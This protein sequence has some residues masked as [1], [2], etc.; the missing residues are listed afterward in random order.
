MAVVESKL[1]T[2]SLMLGTAPGTEFACQATNVRI[3][4]TFNEEGDEVETLCGDVLAPS[5]TA[6]YAM[7]G[8]DIQDWDAP[9]GAGIVHYSWV[10]N[11][12]TVP[13]TWKPNAST[14]VFSGN[15]QVRALE[16]G[17][18][19]NVR[20]TSDFDWPITGVPTVTWAAATSTDTGEE[21]EEPPPEDDKPP[22]DD[23]LPPEDDRPVEY[24]NG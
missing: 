20:I 9:A 5:T 13:F 10:N 3:V 4:P 16:V 24:S 2:G 18:D 19:V 23:D 7:Q 22:A 15:V 1:K 8:T 6:S 17:G 12:L 21:D 14:V 11:L